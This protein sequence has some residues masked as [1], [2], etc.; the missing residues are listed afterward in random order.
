[1]SQPATRRRFSQT[2]HFL[3][4]SP[5]GQLS[6][7]RSKRIAETLAF[8]R[9]VSWPP[10]VG[11]VM[12]FTSPRSPREYIRQSGSCQTSL[13]PTGSPPCHFWLS[14]LIVR[15]AR[16]QAGWYMISPS[17]R[18]PNQKQCEFGCF[19]PQDL[20]QTLWQRLFRCSSFVRVCVAAGRKMLSLRVR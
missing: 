15:C 2:L 7:Q 9:T 8:F 5:Q 3:V 16:V 18:L 13:S 4:V 19:G 20:G 14:L 11:L 17:P 6:H 10:C 12:F 1:M